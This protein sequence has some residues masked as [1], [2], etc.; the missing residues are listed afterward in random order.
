MMNALRAKNKL[1]FV[2]GSL[3]KL[4]KNDEET[5]DWEK[6][7]SMVISWIF[8]ALV[9]KLHDSVA[10]VDTIWEMW[11]DLQERFSQ[12]N[13]PRIHELKMEIWLAQQKD[14]TVAAC[15]TKLK[16]LWD[17]L[18]SYSTIPS[19]KCGARK[20]VIAERKKGKVHQFLM[21]LSDQYGII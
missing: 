20:E 14:L 11:K 18:A 9:P 19:C 2:D 10:Y 4:D 7:N 17:E 21:G 8:N 16:G 15:Y 5:R 6:C 3:S 12:G 13:V 1:S